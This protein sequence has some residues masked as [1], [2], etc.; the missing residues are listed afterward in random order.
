[1]QKRILFSLIFIALMFES[2][3][4][5]ANTQESEREIIKNAVEVS[6]LDIDKNPMKFQNKI[7][8]LKGYAK[9]WAAK[10]IPEDIRKL[11]LNLP[12]A[13]NNTSPSR[14][15]GS[16]TDKTAVILYP[17]HPRKWMKIILYA[18]IKVVKDKW[19]IVPLIESLLSSE[20]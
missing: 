9:G 17:I 2:Y 12:F 11:F 5:F 7:L 8:K 6:I 10:D 20:N 16:F 18:R 13:K 1:M 4:V 15:W 19:Q 3:L 14:N